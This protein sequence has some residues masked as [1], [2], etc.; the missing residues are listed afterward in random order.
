MLCTTIGID[1][2]KKQKGG[3]ITVQFMQISKTIIMTEF[4]GARGF[5]VL[6]IELD[7]LKISSQSDLG[8]EGHGLPKFV[9]LRPN[10]STTN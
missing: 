8:S 9:F 5:F 3:H 7:L 4:Y 6:H 2:I 10:Y 1:R